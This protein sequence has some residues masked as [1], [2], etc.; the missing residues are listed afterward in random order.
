M[1]W[2]QQWGKRIFDVSMVSFL[3]PIWIPI[4][5]L[6]SLVVLISMG[7]PILFVQQRPGFKNKIFRLLKFRTMSLGLSSDAERLTRFGKFL[8]TTSLDELP[9]LFNIL[10]GDMSLVGPRPLLEQYLERYTT[11]QL[12]RHEV[13]PGLTGLVQVNGRNLLSWSDKFDLDIEYVQKIS[14]KLDVKILFKTVLKVLQR[15]GI[16]S[17]NS[18][19]M[20]EF[21]G[22]S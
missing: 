5:C 7:R 19:T 10:K 1:N 17:Q 14:L 22:H 13:K 9:S 12:R 15:Q 8:R 4:V 21:M 20:P 11:E 2:Y 16:S 18:V 6:L 3:S